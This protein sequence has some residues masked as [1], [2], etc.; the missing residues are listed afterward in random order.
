MMGEFATRHGAMLV[1]A[2]ALGDA[3]CALPQADVRELLPL[4]DLWRPP[5][6]P[7]AL[8]GFMRLGDA[9]VPVVKLQR[10]LG[11]NEDGADAASSLYHHLI[12]LRGGPSGGEV[13]LLVPRVLDVVAVSPDRL[14]PSR[15]AETLNGCV[16]AEIE[17]GD[18]YIHLLATERIL[19]ERE[20]SA[21][22]EL[23]EAAQARIT[24]WAG[25]AW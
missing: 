7:S 12:L 6:A 5:G 17:D 24:E 2:F 8:A 9:A 3:R 16:E 1:V 18:G 19:L 20:R 25:G 13:A 15:S 11:A 4:P 22:H 23:T 21:L 10:L 14:R